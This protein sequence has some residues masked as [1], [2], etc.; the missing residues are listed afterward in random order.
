VG[1]K[2]VLPRKVTW[3]FY[4]NSGSSVT[5]NYVQLSWPGDTDNQLLRIKVGDNTYAFN[6]PDSPS[7]TSTSVSVPA[8]GSV[9]IQFEFSGDADATSYSITVN[10]TNGCSLP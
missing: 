4:N 9:K 10:T 7:S 1:N 8:G 3:D 5:I 2:A 6:D